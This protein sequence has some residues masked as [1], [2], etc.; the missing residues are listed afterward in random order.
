M[1]THKQFFEEERIT[2][3]IFIEKKLKKEVE[4]FAQRK[5][6]FMYEAFAELVKNGLEKSNTTKN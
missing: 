2:M 6:V 4:E 1:A 5:D 3:T